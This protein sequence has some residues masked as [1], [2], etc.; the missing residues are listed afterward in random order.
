IIFIFY[1]LYQKKTL[2]HKRVF[3]GVIKNYLTTFLS[4]F[5]GVN[6]GA[7]LAAIVIDAPVFGF[8]PGRAAR[9]RILNVPKPVITTFS[10][11]FKLSRIALSNACTESLA[12]LLVRFAF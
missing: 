3:S 2:Q 9:F 6:P 7:F 11:R 12:A 10:P 1:S 4:V 5:P 8:R